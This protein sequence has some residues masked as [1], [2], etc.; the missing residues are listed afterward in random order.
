MKILYG[1]IAGQLSGLLWKDGGPV[2]GIQFE[3]EY[4]G[5]AEHLLT[6]KKIA[7]EA[8]LDV[9]LYTRTGWPAL[10]H[11]DAVRRNRAALRRLCRGILGPRTDAD[12]RADYWTG[13]HFSTLRTDGATSPTDIARP[14]A[15]RRTRPTSR[16]YPYLTCEIGGGMMNSYHRRILV[17]PARQRIHHAGEARLRRRLA[18]LL[19]VSRRRKSRRQTHHAHGIAGHRDTGTTC[20]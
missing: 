17:N 3:N 12:A 4:S 9:P 1:Q 16:R 18:G 10:P 15:T 11:A 14:N 6:L 5:P 8:G 2:I 13:F 7:R 19:H 20:R